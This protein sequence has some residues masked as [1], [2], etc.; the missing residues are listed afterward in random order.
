L[1]RKKLICKNSNLNYFSSVNHIQGLISESSKTFRIQKLEIEDQLTDSESQKSNI[2]MRLEFDSEVENDI[3][4]KT[5]LAE[6]EQLKSI[7]LRL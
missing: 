6:I 2:M 3:W 7:S 1:V 4:M 5:I